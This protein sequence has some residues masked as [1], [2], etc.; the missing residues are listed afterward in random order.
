MYACRHNLEEKEKE[1]V[2]TF[3]DFDKSCFFI[4]F[5]FFGLG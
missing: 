5:I 4:F 2:G 3:D 1:K